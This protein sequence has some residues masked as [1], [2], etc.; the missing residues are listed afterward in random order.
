[1]IVEQILF[2]II[3]FTIFVYMFFKMMRMN[4]ISYVI[5]L[6][7]EAIGIGID[8]IEVLFGVQINVLLKV[9]KYIF[10][11]ILPILVIIMEK[12]NK[13]LAEFSNIQKAK[14]YLKFGNN[15]KA[16][17]ILIDLASKFPENYLAHRLL[18]EVYEEE[19]GMRKAIDEYVQA[20]D[21]NKQDYDSYF[22]VAFLLNNLN[23]K[24]E[25]EQMLYGLIT[26]KPDYYEASILLGDLLI[27]KE[28]YK[29]AV[30]IYQEA[31][32][33]KP[34]SFDLNY[35]IAIV[36]TMLNDFQSAKM[37][38][39]R[40]AQLNSL[41]YNSK[42]SLAEIALMYK[43]LD[44]AERLFLEAVEDDELSADGYLELS[45]IYLIKKDKDTAIKYA[46]IA[47]DIDAKKIVDK[48]QIDAIFIPILGRV[49]I[50]FNLESRNEEEE[51]TKKKK[52]SEKELKAKQHLE[53]M[54]EI[55]R[56]LGYNDIKLLKKDDIKSKQENKYKENEKE[57][58]KERDNLSENGF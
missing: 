30:N 35:N 5:L 13:T 33:Y 15:K 39:E 50:P 14:I 49:S 16:K 7:L 44:E 17:K 8:F 28:L 47:I 22:K 40:A 23:K 10:S 9:L 43:N 26:K 57:N 24:E 29:E 53:E 42:Y 6:V 52:L 2:I 55:T 34:E 58:I 41:S 12:N 48:I 32:K 51:N 11:M 27:E 1:M 46:N 3:S 38:Y 37:Y 56:N 20:I 36:Y 54:F 4:D 45:K 18:A 21:L 19:G 25:A 31:L